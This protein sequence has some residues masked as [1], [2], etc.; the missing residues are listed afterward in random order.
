MA[1]KPWDQ[2]RERQ[3]PAL[4]EELSNKTGGLHFHVR[5]DAEAKQAMIKI[6]EAVRNEYVIGYQPAESGSPGKWHRVRVKSDVPKVNVYSRN[7]YY[8]Q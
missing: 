2:A 7:G 6:G 5:D 4:L 8:V 3:G 1:Q